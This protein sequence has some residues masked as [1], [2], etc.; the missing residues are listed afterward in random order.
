MASWGGSCKDGP[1]P[2]LTFPVLRSPE[3]EGLPSCP[4][5]HSD[6][7]EHSR[8]RRGSLGRKGQGGAGRGRGPTCP[9][10]ALC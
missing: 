8:L 7:S 3:G 5:S 10:Q 9:A 4:L 2:W 6:P 1:V